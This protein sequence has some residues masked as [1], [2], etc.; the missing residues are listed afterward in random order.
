MFREVVHPCFVPQKRA[1][2]ALRRRVHG[3]HGHA[4]TTTHSVEAKPL[5]EGALARPRNPRKSNTH[6]LSRTW[7]ETQQGFIAVLV[8][9]GHFPPGRAPLTLPFADR[10]GQRL[11]VQAW[12]DWMSARAASRA[13]AVR[14]VWRRR[15]RT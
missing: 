14:F 5:D 12:A 2:G 11:G 8:V 10:V 7:R 13:R 6:A 9:G 15:R 1:L 4:C 3:Q